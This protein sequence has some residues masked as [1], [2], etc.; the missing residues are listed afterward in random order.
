M[1]AVEGAAPFPIPMLRRSGGAEDHDVGP[2]GFEAL[3]V[4]GEGT[5]DEALSDR[6]PP[7]GRVFVADADLI[8]R[9]GCSWA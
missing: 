5:G 1:R 3:P 6:F 4:V 8:S 9:L 2:G 7:S